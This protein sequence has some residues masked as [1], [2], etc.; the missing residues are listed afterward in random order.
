MEASPVLRWS[1]LDAGIAGRRV[2]WEL[3][4]V[5]EVRDGVR[6]HGG[7]QLT[8][9]ARD[10]RG[11]AGEASDP[12]RVR[13]WSRLRDLAVRA[14]PRDGGWSIREDPFDHAWHMRRG[15]D[16]EPELQWS[17]VLVPREDGEGG[18]AER[19]LA[20]AVRLGFQGLGVPEA[21]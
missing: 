4:P 7:L 5:T 20:R 3:T 6:A 12:E 19:D 16:W 8:L 14:L 17:G 15:G 2:C 18:H 11:L 10:P 21:R 9:L 13:A 1:A